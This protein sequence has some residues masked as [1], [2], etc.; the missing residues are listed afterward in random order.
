MIP[1]RNYR[2]SDSTLQVLIDL[3]IPLHSNW[4]G[5]PKL[6]SQPITNKQHVKLTSQTMTLE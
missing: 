5:L 2:K 4:V 6:I 3:N 1:S